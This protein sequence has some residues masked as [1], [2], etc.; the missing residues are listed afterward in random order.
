GG[1][2]LPGGQ[3][4]GRPRGPRPAFGHARLQVGAGAPVRIVDTRRPRIAG[5]T[6]RPGLA[7][8]DVIVHE[9]GNP[10]HGED[11]LVEESPVELRYN[12]VSFA[13]MM[14]TPVDL[15]DFAYGFS[16]SEDRVA[17]AGEI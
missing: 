12:G 6:T 11:W 1:D 3:R 9:G 5:M 2:V 14:A 10:C 17:R 15:E 4:A 16:L 13:V 7:R 8:H